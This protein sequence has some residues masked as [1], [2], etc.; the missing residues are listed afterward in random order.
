M[1]SM[2]YL[3]IDYFGHRISILAEISLYQLLLSRRESHHLN[4]HLTCF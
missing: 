3:P 1:K 4:W 2:S